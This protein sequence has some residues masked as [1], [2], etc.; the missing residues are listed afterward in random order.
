MANDKA[1][2][3]KNNIK[4]D[5]DIPKV[6]D[7]SVLP[8]QDLQNKAKELGLKN[9]SQLNKADLQKLIEDKIKKEEDKIPDYKKSPLNDKTKGELVQIA[10]G[11]SIKNYSR[12]SKIDLIKSIQRNT[13]EPKVKDIDAIKKPLLLPTSDQN[14]EVKQNLVSLD[15]EPQVI[16]QI[17][18]SE[19]NEKETMEN[20]D[21]EKPLSFFE[22]SKKAIKSFLHID[23]PDAPEEKPV[24]ET[25]PVLD[26]N[27]DEVPVTQNIIPEETVQEHSEQAPEDLSSL[28][29][30][31]LVS[32]AKDLKVKGYSRLNKNKLIKSISEIKDSIANKAEEIKVNLT[33]SVDSFTEAFNEKA[34]AFNKTLENI[35][36]GLEKAKEVVNHIT[37][38][39][40]EAFHHD[41]NLV[42]IEETTEVTDEVNDKIVL[43]VN[44]PKEE[45]PQEVKVKKEIVKKSNKTSEKVEISQSLNVEDSLIIKPE[46]KTEENSI[47]NQ[48]ESILEEPELPDTAKN[49]EKIAQGLES[50]YLDKREAVAIENDIKNQ[51]LLKPSKYG[52]GKTNK[53]YLLEDEENIKLPELYEEDKI[54]LLPVD[55]T[56]M[57][58]YWDLSSE[59]INYFLQNKIKDFYIRV[60]D[61]TEIIY[62]GYNANLYWL[63]KCRI[64]IGNWYIYLDQGGR[65]FCVEIGYVD[66]GVFNI[67]AKSNS[68]MIAPGKASQVI[69][70]TFVISNYPQQV[71]TVTKGINTKYANARYISGNV[72]AKENPY[73]SLNDY[74][75][76]QNY[77]LRKMAKKMPR[78]TIEDIAEHFVKEYQMTGPQENKNVETFNFNPPEKLN[79]EPSAISLS[80]LSNKAIMT[81]NYANQSVEPQ[82]DNSQFNSKENSFEYET[83]KYMQSIQVSD[84]SINILEPITK[85]IGEIPEGIYS[86]F[87]SIP[88]FSQDKILID[89]FYYHLP[90]E[91]HKAIR[92]YYE[93]TENETPYRKEFFWVS[94]KSPQ[95]HQNIYKISWGPTWVKE[96]IGG[97]EQIKYIG[98][99]ERFLGGSEVFLGGSEYFIESSGRYMGSSEAYGGNED[100]YQGASEKMLGGSENYSEW[101]VKFPGASENMTGGSENYQRTEFVNV[102]SDEFILKSNKTRAQDYKGIKDRYKL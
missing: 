70:D 30:A 35:E 98:A 6:L 31:S 96:F 11:M 54:T 62:N 58:V 25:N 5:L 91:P 74:K 9:F 18:T 84:E 43:E 36:E 23:Q 77:N 85:I 53:E 8:K 100:N 65:N 7:Y 87:E 67:I 81:N 37:S 94:D 79:T 21:N 95:V 19:T 61:V 72:E 12:L 47:V 34:D 48:E 1:K 86:Y 24:E 69:S 90:G 2:S 49:V 59:T 78:F 97:S 52:F 27:V 68:V 16:T 41:P 101:S 102:S 14:S 82:I 60:S 71:E 10:K 28:S 33:E 17:N 15:V 63:E 66:Q 32:I 99:S 75:I 46:P 3:D 42:S 88:G 26:N 57:F 40:K 92:V 56:K 44:E 80:R 73:Y 93:W 89:S 13:A 50:P 22:R 76:A 29:V 64:E 83:D 45:K 39:M 51:F 20:K 4:K 38:E 55:P